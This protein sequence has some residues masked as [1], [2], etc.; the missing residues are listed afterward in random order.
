MFKSM[1]TCVVC[2]L[3]GLA[4][5]V[6]VMNMPVSAQTQDNK[7]D[8]IVSEV[9]RIQ[10]YIFPG[11]LGV[12]KADVK[13]IGTADAG[14]FGVRFN[15]VND[16]RCVSWVA[17]LK[18]GETQTV[19]CGYSAE[20]AGDLHSEVIVDHAFSVSESDE[21][22]NSLYYRFTVSP[23]TQRS[24]IAVSSFFKKLPATLHGGDDVAL[25][26]TVTNDSNWPTGTFATE[27]FVDDGSKSI[28]SETIS[29][30]ANE[31]LIVSCVIRELNPT[32]S[33]TITFQADRLDRIAEIDE[34]N[35]IFIDEFTVNEPVGEPYVYTPEPDPIPEEPIN[36]EIIEEP[37]IPDNQNGEV[38]GV[39]D[40]APAEE[41]MVTFE[42]Q[43]GALLDG[44]SDA[45]PAFEHTIRSGWLVELQQSQPA[46][47]SEVAEALIDFMAYGVDSVTAK[48][49]AGE[50]AAVL[51]SYK[52]AYGKLPTTENEIAD[53]LRIANGRWPVELNLDAQDR[54]H[55]N[56]YTI[57]KRI[58][59][60]SNPHDNA[61]I[62]VMTYGLKQ[63]PENRN[64]DSERA[65]IKTFRAI[66]GHS[67]QTTREWNIM[68]AITYSGASR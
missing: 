35:N 39:T 28:C 25:F 60:M 33:M 45:D 36:P 46:L 30:E 56:F 19:W 24:D 5:F 58:A 6:F 21:T 32:P 10:D 47:S 37:T 43:A 68:Q 7:A 12:Y 53:V 2:S 61:A 67:P 27:W 13:N 31:S 16:L 65:G 66:F 3:L 26:A 34:S 40:E 55:K 49:G 15:F 11:N 4:G 9:S 44:F 18:V 63:R 52:D 54:S 59:D 29:L 48:L 51:F 23:V 41:V 57:Y 50:R 22:N 62:T 8:L 42:S 20:Y 17:S 64:L 38:L 14:R 1:L